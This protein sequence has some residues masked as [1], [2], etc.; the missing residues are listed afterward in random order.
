MSNS[1]RGLEFS[2]SRGKTHPSAPVRNESP[3]GTAAPRGPRFFSPRM[4][5]Q[6]RGPWFWISA[7]WPVVAGIALIAMESTKYFGADHTTGPLRRIFQALFGM[8]GDARWQTIH[9]LIRKS[10]HFLGYGMLGL[11]WLRAW[12]M[13]V[14]FARFLF[15]AELALAGTALVAIC[16]EW[17]QSF[18]PNR[19]SSPLDVLLDCCGALAMQW[20]VYICLRLS[21]HRPLIVR[22]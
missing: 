20:I 18:L 16:D 21:R 7:W 12:W 3:L 1:L 10:G 8:V 13:T 2:A 15:D 19:T 5:T 4:K 14:P 9:L 11:A 22:N 6:P 17:H